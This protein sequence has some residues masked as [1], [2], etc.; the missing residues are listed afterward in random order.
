MFPT[1]ILRNVTRNVETGGLGIPSGRH[2]RRY[3]DSRGW[4][5]DW[6]V[7]G[8]GEEATW[9][10]RLPKQLRLLVL[11]SLLPSSPYQLPI[12]LVELVRPVHILIRARWPYVLAYINSP[13][14]TH[15]LP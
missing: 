6:R 3:I 10:A 4:L 7:V 12:E 13:F 9:T 8:R 11:T 5:V 15:F 2:Y 14:P 1:L